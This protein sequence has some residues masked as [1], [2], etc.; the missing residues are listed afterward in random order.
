LDHGYFQLYSDGK[1]HLGVVN[2]VNAEFTCGVVLIS[3]GA[4][5]GKNSPLEDLLEVHIFAVTE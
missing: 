3:F 5:L 4:V 1:I 2:L